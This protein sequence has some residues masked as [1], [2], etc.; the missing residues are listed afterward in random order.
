MVIF[1]RPDSVVANDA[2]C[3]GMHA[4]ALEAALLQECQRGG[5]ESIIMNIANSF[6]QLHNL[7]ELFHGCSI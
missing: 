2:R 5:K 6:V 1:R 4:R 3:A 7:H